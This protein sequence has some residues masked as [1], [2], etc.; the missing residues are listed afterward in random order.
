MSNELSAEKEIVK[1]EKQLG[2]DYANELR[3]LN[4]EQ[5]EVKLSQLAKHNQEIDKAK[6]DDV[7]LQ[8][9]RERVRDMSAPYNES[10]KMNK[11]RTRLLYLIMTDERGQE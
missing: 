3:A 11:L 1:L 7:E 6:K 9:A 5:L 4:A 8:D 10:K 2:S